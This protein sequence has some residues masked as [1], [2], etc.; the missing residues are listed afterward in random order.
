MTT[1]RP[2]EPADLRTLRSIQEHVLAEPWPELLETAVSG[3]PPLFVLEDGGR[4]GYTIA[5][6]GSE[7]VYVSELAIR[8]DR[9]N[10]GYG[11]VLVSFL[12]DQ[13]EDYDELQLIVEATDERARRFYKRHGFDVLDRLDDNFESGDGLLLV[14]PL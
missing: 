4:V 8:P 9:Q 2:G 6:P 3:A 13:F 10:E 1:I 11:S 12:V 14:R 5:I 7:A